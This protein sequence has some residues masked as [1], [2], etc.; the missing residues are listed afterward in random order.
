MPET[1]L[2]LVKLAA[3]LLVP[4]LAADV[5]LSVRAGELRAEMRN[6]VLWRI[7]PRRARLAA[8]MLAILVAA[9]LPL[10]PV[11]RGVIVLMAV[12][13]GA[14]LLIQKGR[15]QGRQSLA[16]AAAVVLTLAAIVTLPIELLILNRMFPL[17]LHA[18]V[19]ALVSNILPKLLIPLVVGAAL[20]RTWPKGADVLAPVVRVLFYVAARASWPLPHWPATWQQ[21]GALHPWVWLAMLAVTLGAAALVDFFGGRENR[22]IGRRPP[23][24]SFRN[25]AVAIQVAAF[26]YP[27]SS[28]APSSSPTS[29]CVRFSFCPTRSSRVS[30]PGTA[31]TA[32]NLS[33]RLLFVSLSA[34]ENEA[35]ELLQRLA[36]RHL[37]QHQRKE[38]DG[39]RQSHHGDPGPWYAERHDPTTLAPPPGSTPGRRGT[40]CSALPSRESSAGPR[41]HSLLE[42]ARVGLREAG[43]PSQTL[44][45][46]PV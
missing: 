36:E 42:P 40:E 15:S 8:W 39:D 21:L 41:N 35:E 45:A 13:P 12:S 16:V 29:F 24:P 33:A 38:R 4:C 6:P 5:G 31:R 43:V 18:S 3:A 28:F 26:S 11:A 10:G 25:P 37:E 44:E 20:R 2:T 32:G 17:R 22:T 34:A 30:S 19:P 1:V 9:A 23:M 14:P 46:R 7:L 27:S